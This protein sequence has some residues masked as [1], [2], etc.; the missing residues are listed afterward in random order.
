[1]K[2]HGADARHPGL[3][4]LL[5]EEGFSDGA[6][7]K[8]ARSRRPELRDPQDDRIASVHQRLDL[9]YRHQATGTG[10]IAMPLTEWAFDSLIVR[11]RNPFDND[12]RRRREWQPGPE[13][14]NHLDRFASQAAGPI[15]FAHAVWQGRGAGQQQQRIVTERHGYLHRLTTREQ[16]VAVYQRVVPRRDVEAERLLIVDHD[17]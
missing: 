12:L 10:I 6:G 15:V 4:H 14:F 1:M 9:D 8:Q 5:H 2:V 16:R 13:S 17:A 7:E 3:F 11:V